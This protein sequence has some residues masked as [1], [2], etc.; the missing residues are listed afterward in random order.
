MKDKENRRLERQIDRLLR[1]LPALREPSEAL[2]QR[3]WGVVRVP[4]AVA[5]I[6]GGVFSFLPLLGAWMLPLGLLLLAVDVPILRKPASRGIIGVRRWISLKLR[7][8]RK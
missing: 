4:V 2:M 3:G 8:F 6:L 7:A 1:P 5:L